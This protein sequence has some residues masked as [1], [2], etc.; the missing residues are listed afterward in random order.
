[1]IHT[2][3]WHFQPERNRLTDAAADKLSNF[4]E[5]SAT[6]IQY[7]IEKHTRLEVNV[8]VQPNYV[9]VPHGGKYIEYVLQGKFSLV[10]KITLTHD[11]TIYRNE[12]PLMII[13]LGSI[14]LKTEPRREDSKDVAAMHVAGATSEDILK[15]IMDQAYDKFNLNIDN[16][17]VDYFSNSRPKQSALTMYVFQLIWF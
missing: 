5:R 8:S 2:S 12:V 3:K 17:Q 10:A 1:M 13:S 11:F 4:K 15:E 6:G 9:I 7:M 14:L 16:I